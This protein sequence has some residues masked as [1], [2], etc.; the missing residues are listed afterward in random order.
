MVGYFI[1]ILNHENLQVLAVALA[2][3]PVLNSHRWLEA[4]TL[5]STDVDHAHYHCRFYWTVDAHVLCSQSVGFM[6]L[7]VVW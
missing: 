5:D 7:W 3:S 4:A 2:T 6:V 1:L